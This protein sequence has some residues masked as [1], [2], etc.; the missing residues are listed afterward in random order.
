MHFYIKRIKNINNNERNIATANA[1]KVFIV[2]ESFD[3][4]TPRKG[5]M[6]FFALATAIKCLE[7]ENYQ[8]LQRI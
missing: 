1:V 4:S 5:T 7:N 6:T 2:I 8:Y 3:P